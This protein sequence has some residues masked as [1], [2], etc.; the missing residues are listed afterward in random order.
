MLNIKIKIL[1]KCIKKVS[2][3]FDNSQNIIKKITYFAVR[4]V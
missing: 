2:I 3:I 1:C 4:W